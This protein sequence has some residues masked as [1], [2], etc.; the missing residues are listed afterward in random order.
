M[1]CRPKRGLI[2]RP[3]LRETL[4][5]RQQV[6]GL[7]D[8]VF[9]KPGIIEKFAPIVLLGL[10]HEQQHQELM[11]ADIKHVFSENPLRPVFRKRSRPKSAPVSPM[12]WLM[13]PAGVFQVGYEGNG[14]N[15]DNEGPRH[16]Q[17][18]E[19]FQLSPRLVTIV[20]YL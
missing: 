13:F 10:H 12:P 3:T 4:E 18:V 15:F 16:R 19:T 8:A 17:F 6:D 14:F 20:E 1:H 5:Y 11:L 9:E 2:S 7:M